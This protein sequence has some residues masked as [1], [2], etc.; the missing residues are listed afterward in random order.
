MTEQ[1]DILVQKLVSVAG[2]ENVDQVGEN[3]VVKPYLAQEIAEIM[4]LARQ[5]NIPVE[6]GSYAI[7]PAAS[8]KPGKKII[9]ALD[10]MDQIL[11][12][13]QNLTLTTG[14]AAK[15]DEIAK[16]V[17]EKELV[18][19]GITCSH[20]GLT[21]GKNVAACFSEGEPDFK[22][23][24][25]CLCGL[26]M[27]LFDGTAITVGEIAAKDYDN[28]HLSYMLGGY[29]HEKAIITGIHLKLLLGEREN[30]WLVTSCADISKSMDVFPSIV[31]SY[32][33]WLD[34]IMAVKSDLNPVLTDVLAKLFPAMPEAG[35][36][37]LMSVNCPP[38]KL[39]PILDGLTDVLKQAGASETLIAK[40]TYQKLVLASCYSTLAGEL[41]A[42][43]DMTEISAGEM[44]SRPQIEDSR[45]FAVYRQ[46]ERE[47]VKMFI[48]SGH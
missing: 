4:R 46:N 40:D 28:Y 23:Q 14:P 31:K 41:D 37:V 19:P 27:V 44:E 34:K 38:D 26:E 6:A 13:S 15:M 45:L 20:K 8:S 25:A 11:F 29:R 9:L 36:Y 39:E 1:N 18:F 21:V 48:K 10:R 24:V 47:T 16:L 7:G 17:L 3:I 5:N 35:A 2:M 30:F 22:C 43:P 33:G 42:N 32:Q 12:N